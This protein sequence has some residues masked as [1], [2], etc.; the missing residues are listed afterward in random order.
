[1]LRLDP[2]LSPYAELSAARALGV[3]A[4][5]E[6]C[7][8]PLSCFF[9]DGH[10]HLLTHPKPLPSHSSTLDHRPISPT[11]RRRSDLLRSKSGHIGV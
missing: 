4:Q 11:R 5:S 6:P 3:K 10:V 1:M 7:P 8:T 9:L 2:E